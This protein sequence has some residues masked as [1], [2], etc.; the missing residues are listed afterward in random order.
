MENQIVKIICGKYP[1]DFQKVEIKSDENYIFENDP[2]YNAVQLF[3][4][5]E[6]TVYVNSFVECEHYVLGGWDQNSTILVES[7]LI[8]TTAIIFVLAVLLKYLF[9]KKKVKAL[10]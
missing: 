6:N 9:L 4:K 3:D 5:D 2:T 8:Q 1:D 7:Q 10:S